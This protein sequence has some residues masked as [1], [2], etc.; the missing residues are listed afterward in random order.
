MLE[1]VT[2]DDRDKTR[3]KATL[4]DER[5]LALGAFGDRGDLVRDLDVFGQVQA[6][7]EAHALA[8]ATLDG[9][10]TPP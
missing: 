1:E 3:R 9:E 6:A 5:S 2:R 7:F 8:T 10:F 4:R